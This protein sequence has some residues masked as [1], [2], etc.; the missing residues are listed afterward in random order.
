MIGCLDL[1]RT[2]DE[3]TE[4]LGSFPELGTARAR[5]MELAE[6][7]PGHYTIYDQM[8]GKRLFYQLFFKE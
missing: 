8:T 4:W 3:G 5:L 6:G 7:A 1:Y 2:T